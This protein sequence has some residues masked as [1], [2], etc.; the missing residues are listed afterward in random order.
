M[1][2]LKSKVLIV[3]AHMQNALEEFQKPVSHL[4]LTHGHADY[5]G[6]AAY[7]HKIIL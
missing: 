2:I 5:Y 3:A 4:I 6:G 1:S 7:F